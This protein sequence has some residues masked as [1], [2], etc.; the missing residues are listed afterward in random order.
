M[1][2]IKEQL[3]REPKM[4]D[5]I[6]ILEYISQMML[7]QGCRQEMRPSRESKRQKASAIE[8]LKQYDNDARTILQTIYLPYVISNLKESV[9]DDLKT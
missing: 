6:I 2:W 9:S 5:M 8:W 4:R 1:D 3:C 7:K